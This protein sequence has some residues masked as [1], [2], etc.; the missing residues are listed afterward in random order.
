MD[1][2]MRSATNAELAKGY[3]KVL[4]I[5]PMV[6]PDN[7]PPILGSNLQVEKSLLEKSG[8]QVLIISGD[9]TSTL[10][11]GTNVLDPANRKGSAE[12]GLE[13]GRKLAERVQ[14]FWS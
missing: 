7:I 1:G 5:V 9:E 12:A 10:A 14:Q 8:S 11:M 6:Q 4:I 2:G 13:Q 3:D